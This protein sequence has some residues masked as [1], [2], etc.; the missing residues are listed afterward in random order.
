MTQRS[1]LPRSFG[2]IVCLLVACWNTPKAGAQVTS[3][4]SPKGMSRPS[5]AQSRL[6]PA[7]GAFR[8]PTASLAIVLKEQL[9]DSNDARALVVRRASMTPQNVIV[10]SP[11]TTASDLALA[12]QVLFISRSKV[13][14]SL[15]ADIVARIAPTQ[16]RVGGSSKEVQAAIDLAKLHEMKP[17]DF[18]EVSGI[19]RHAVLLSRLGAARL[20]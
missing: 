17:S 14:D 2:V 19:G 20:R 5:S 3:T 18:R 4:V 11:R 10:V 8:A 16:R 13:G 12:V 7:K 15:T 6:T 1:T 9:E